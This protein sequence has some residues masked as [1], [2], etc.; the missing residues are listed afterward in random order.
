MLSSDQVL[1]GPGSKQVTDLGM[2]RFPVSHLGNH[3][4]KWWAEK[5]SGKRNFSGGTS[6]LVGKRNDLTKVWRP[7]AWFNLYTAIHDG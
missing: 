5:I 3:P 7:V 2:G 1:P 6:I 4:G